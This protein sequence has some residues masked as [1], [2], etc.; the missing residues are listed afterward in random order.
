MSKPLVIVARSSC[1]LCHGSGTFFEK[2]GNGMEE[3]MDCDCALE[4]LP[5]TWE[6]QSKIE[7][8]DY[9]IVPST[10]YLDQPNE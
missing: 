5:D 10:K 1:K 9:I 2:H 8:G 7:N 6:I 3:M 4:D